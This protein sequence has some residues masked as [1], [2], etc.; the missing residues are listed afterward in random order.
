M[1]TKNKV[2]LPCLKEMVEC[3]F[4]FLVKRRGIS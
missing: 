1:K 4:K 3:N 2:P